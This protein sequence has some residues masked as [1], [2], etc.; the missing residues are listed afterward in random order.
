M[1]LAAHALTT[2]TA[3]AQT[4]PGI[5]VEIVQYA[6]A[7]DPVVVPAGTTITWTN[8]DFVA[9]TVTSD[10]RSF[11]SDLFSRGEAWSWTFDA[12]GVYGYYCLPHGSPGSGM[13]GVIEVLGEGAPPAE[14]PPA[15]E[16][17]AE[18]VPPVEEAPVE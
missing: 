17:P 1:L 7:P 9:H 2:A 3:A 10:D 18:E 6:Y 16:P 15:E 8:K 5:S 4:A 12:P 13:I 11:D 14:E